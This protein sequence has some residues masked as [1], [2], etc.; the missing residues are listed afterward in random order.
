M[1][2]A[3]YITTVSSDEVPTFAIANPMVKEGGD[4]SEPY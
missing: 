3:D 4:Q 1:K 2:K